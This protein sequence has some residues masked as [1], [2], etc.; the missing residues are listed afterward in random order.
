MQK[1]GVEI[2]W[3]F[4]VMNMYEHVVSINT[5]DEQNARM[6]DQPRVTSVL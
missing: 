3:F 1:T 4:V 5:R 6:V 2:P